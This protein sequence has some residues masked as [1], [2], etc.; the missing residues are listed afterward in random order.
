ML[1]FY[2]IIGCALAATRVIT[3]FPFGAP[4]VACGTMMPFHVP[5]FYTL[6]NSPFVLVVSS[7]TASANSPITGNEFNNFIHQN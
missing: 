2:L 7:T 4:A 5:F 1:N 3:A 6:P